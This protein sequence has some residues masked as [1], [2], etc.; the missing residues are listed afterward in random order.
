M[1]ITLTT[2]HPT[3][4]KKAAEEI[5]IGL[6]HLVQIEGKL[7][8]GSGY[9]TVRIIAENCPWSDAEFGFKVGMKMKSIN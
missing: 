4:V 1:N 9:S 5:L 8:N 3:E 2:F 6:P 7:G